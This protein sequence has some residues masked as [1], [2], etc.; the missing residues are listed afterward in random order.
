MAELLELWMSTLTC[1][2]AWIPDESEHQ[3]L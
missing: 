2:S 3:E 1:G